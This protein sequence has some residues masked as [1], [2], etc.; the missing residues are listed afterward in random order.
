[1]LRRWLWLHDKGAKAKVGKGRA[2]NVS[3]GQAELF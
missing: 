3:E 2:R 1:M